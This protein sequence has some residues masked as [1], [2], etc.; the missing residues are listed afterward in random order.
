M[1]PRD[2][3]LLPR[4]LLALDSLEN[5]AEIVL[6][7]RQVRRI[8]ST[9]RSSLSKLAQNITENITVRDQISM[10]DDRQ[11]VAVRLRGLGQLLSFARHPDRATEAALDRARAAMLQGTSVAGE[12]LRVALACLHDL[13]KNQAAPPQQP[14][15]QAP[16]YRFYRS[17]MDTGGSPFGFGGPS[18]DGVP[19]SADHIAALM[20]LM[21]AM[22]MRR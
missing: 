11:A 18:V 4:L 3:A 7:V 21:R 14:F 9:E 15:H 10:N 8:L 5:D 17:P 19:L 16:Q 1:T 20:E 6:A 13:L 12:D 22:Q 2:A